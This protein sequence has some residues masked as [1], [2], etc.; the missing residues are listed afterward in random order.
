MSLTA[1][2]T[3]S[4]SVLQPRITGERLFFVQDVLQ[5][6]NDD[7]YGGGPFFVQLK[8]GSMERITEE[9]FNTLKEALNKYAGI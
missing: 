5:L 3:L 1:V 4:E 6:V 9:S 8:G 2:N 7:S